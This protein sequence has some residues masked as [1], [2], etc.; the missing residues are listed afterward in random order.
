MKHILVAIIFFTSSSALALNIQH[1]H[2]QFDGTGT[3][4]LENSQTLDKGEI[5]AGFYL[6]VNRNPLEFASAT[7]GGV[8]DD[9]VKWHVGA[10]AV[11]AYGITDYFEAGF[12]IKGN[13]FTNVEDPGATVDRHA[14][15]FSDLLIKAKLSIINFNGEKLKFGLGFLPFVSFPTG[16]EADFVG[17][18]QIS[19]GLRAIA[20]F[21]FFDNTFITHAGINIREREQIIGLDVD[22]EILFGLGYMRPIVKKLGLYAIAEL[23]GS[24][25]ARHFLSRE[26]TTPAEL[27]FAVRKFFLNKKL[28][29]TVSGGLGIGNGYGSPDYRTTAGISY[30]FNLFSH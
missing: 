1:F 6:D 8:V 3:L 14:S 30:N 17:D 20:D 19:G 22:D 5:S 9:I 28:A 27:N 4:T 25:V 13:P 16:K 12:D 18:N 29:A 7:A 11:A 10:D 23:T 15:A 26:N 21:T 2:P 24:T